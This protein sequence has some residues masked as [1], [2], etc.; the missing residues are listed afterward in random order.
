MSWKWKPSSYTVANNGRTVQ[1][2]LQRLVA[3]RMDGSVFEADGS[4]SQADLV[5]DVIRKV[6]NAVPQESKALHRTCL[7]E[8]EGSLG[9]A[10]GEA[11]LPTSAEFERTY[12][13]IVDALTATVINAEAGLNWLSAQRPDLEEVRRTLNMIAKDGKRAGEIVIRLRAP[14]KRSLQRGD[15]LDP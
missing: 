1:P 12:G 6:A 2:E 4:Q 13:A 14:M 3:N 7:R 5:L 8:P 11:P 10:K 9:D 15:P